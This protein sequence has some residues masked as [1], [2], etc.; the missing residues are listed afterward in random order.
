MPVVEGVDPATE[1]SAN[2]PEFNARWQAGE[3]ARANFTDREDFNNAQ[4]GELGTYSA[5]LG[6]ASARAQQYLLNRVP[7]IGGVPGREILAMRSNPRR[8]FNL[9][10][11]A[12][13]LSAGRAYTEESGYFHTLT[14]LWDRFPGYNPGATGAI[15][16]EGRSFVVDNA[17]GYEAGARLDQM[18]HAM[19]PVTIDARQTT[20]SYA[21]NMVFRGAKVGLDD[22]AVY[23]SNPHAPGLVE[24]HDIVMNTDFMSTSASPEAAAEF[25]MRIRN[26]DSQA[27]RYENLEDHTKFH[28]NRV[29]FAIDQ[30]SGRNVAG[31]AREEQAEVL[32]PPGKFFQINKIDKSDYGNIVRMQEVDRPGDG[33]PVKNMML[34][35]DETQWCKPFYPS[36]T[37]FEYPWSAALRRAGMIP[38]PNNLLSRSGAD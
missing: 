10:N 4:G 3:Y 21:G 16:P 30:Q 25:V 8:F 6:I 22:R 27:G 23:S 29:L 1:F 5:D 2:T 33:T 28:E 7:P 37:K 17:S 34:G 9:L 31:L 26:W 18:L 13:N 15:S 24:P 11:G 38:D 32:F 19:E 12:R 20:R 36:F 35:R 14:R